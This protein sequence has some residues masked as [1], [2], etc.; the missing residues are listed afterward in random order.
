MLVFQLDVHTVI[1]LLFLGNLTAVGMFLAFDGRL[2]QARAYRFFMASKVLQALGWLLFGLRGQ[3][4]ASLSIEAG[5]VVMILGA[6]LEALALT[7]AKVASRRW[8]KVYARLVLAGLAGLAALAFLPIN[9]VAGVSAM[10]VVLCLTAS[11]AIFRNAAGSV[12]YQVIGTFYALSAV[13][14]ALRF[15]AALALD[16]AFDLFATGPVHSL[17]FAVLFVQLLL[18]GIAFLLM[19]KASEDERLRES[20]SKYRTLVDCAQEAIIIIQELRVVFANPSAISLLDLP[21]AG[22]EGFELQGLIHPDD[23]DTVLE[24]HLLR[25]VGEAPGEAYDLRLQSAAGRRVWVSVSATK[26][27]WRGAPAVMA[28]MTDM[29][30]R[31]TLEVQHE[32]AILDLQNALNEVRTLKGLIPICANCKKI[33]D[34]Q[35][36]WNQIE[37]Y[38]V[39]RTDAVFTHG[40]CPECREMLFPGL[41][42]RRT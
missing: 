28:L 38:I 37:T 33:R 15:W 1:S 18:G 40:V 23:W 41:A 42:D 24:R 34:D 36:Y 2:L 21:E 13:A 6:G 5:N 31:K 35:G 3:I 17:A 39:Q 19:L 8:E 12:L 7:T 10:S 20:E 4:P 14:M 30:A 9:R 29:E 16:R 32:L 27:L 25:L 22:L 11:V 26:I